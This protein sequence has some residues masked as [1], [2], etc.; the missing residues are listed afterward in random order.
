MGEWG[1]YCELLV[2]YLVCRGLFEYCLY[3]KNSSAIL[4]CERRAGADV[5][6]RGGLLV[7]KKTSGPLHLSLASASVHLEGEFVSL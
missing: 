1:Q 4:I 7:L 6:I 5:V 2:L 3:P